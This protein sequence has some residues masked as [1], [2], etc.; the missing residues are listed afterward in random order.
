[1]QGSA[2]LKHFTVIQLYTFLN[3]FLSL[4]RRMKTG[5]W[6]S[7]QRHHAKAMKQGKGCR[8]ARLT[9]KRVKALKSVGFAWEAPKRS[10][11]KIAS[12]TIRDDLK[13]EEIVRHEESALNQRASP[14]VSA[15]DQRHTTGVAVRTSNQA[16]NSQTEVPRTALMSPASGHLTLGS[17]FLYPSSLSDVSSTFGLPLAGGGISIFHNR[18]FW[19]LH[20]QM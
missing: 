6:V 20:S 5:H 16:N 17:P 7:T 8:S 19:I 10:E 3:F 9:S 2:P 11:L 14:P 18:V 13:D 4:C 15:P 12:E 1:M